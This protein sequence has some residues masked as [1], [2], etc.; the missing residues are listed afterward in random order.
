M[1]TAACYEPAALRTFL[2]ASQRPGFGEP[3]PFGRVLTLELVA[4]ALAG[5]RAR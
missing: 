1:L 5:A 3:R 4:R 2:D